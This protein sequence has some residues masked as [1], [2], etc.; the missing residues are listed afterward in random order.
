MHGVHSP[1]PPSDDSNTSGEPLRPLREWELWAVALLVGLIYCA[2]LT[3]VPICGEESRWA[4]VAREMIATGDWIVPRQQGQ[5]FAERPPLGSWAMAAVGLARGQVD[6]VAVRLP[7]A[8][9]TT[10]LAV[11]I[12]LYG[13]IFLSR[14]GALAA[15]LA[16]A[17]FGQVLQIGRLGESEALFSCL[18]ASALLLWHAGYVRGWSPALTWTTGYALTAL[19]A[20]VKGPQAPVYFIAVTGAFLVWRRQWR[21]L[22]SWPHALGLAVFAGI[23]AAWQVPFWL[24]TDWQTVVDVW[25]GLA[26]DRFSFG[27]L[28]KHLVSYPLETFGCLLPWSPLL[29]GL[30]DPKFRRT[31]GSYRE[32]TAFLVIAL[33]MTYPTVWL[34]TGARGRYYMPLYPC[35]ALLVGMVIECCT[36]RDATAQLRRGWRWYVG[37]IGLAAGVIGVAVAVGS[38][39]DFERLA[40]LRLPPLLAC[41]FVLFA[42]ATALVL[43]AAAGRSFRPRPRLAILAISAL[44]GSLQVVVML[45]VKAR[46]LNDLSPDVAALRAQLPAA[47]N[48]VSFGPIAHRFAYY[49][50][51][52]IRELPWPTDTA[53]LPADLEFFCFEQHAG[54][55]PERRHSGRGRTWKWTPGSL[56]FRWEQV[57]WIP[58]DPNRRENPTISV[59]VG[60]AIGDRPIAD[61][62]TGESTAARADSASGSSR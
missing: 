39:A 58:C 12:Y 11:L 25:S 56:P 7:S 27:G 53:Q 6:A 52:P 36:A 30:A 62:Q 1:A 59:V 13:R 37:T 33:V 24:A 29:L 23:V 45:S 34:S 46:A 19:A 16:Y 15:A 5:V 48:M 3:T 41:G 32:L 51:D 54:D 18:L 49:Y 44:L 28:L 31:L 8:L 14:R 55:S 9:A 47:G 60:R 4:G 57:A 38:G 35:F 42:V 21:G 50:G 20:L 2:R 17:T 10:A 61:H 26:R 43:I 22:L 40:I